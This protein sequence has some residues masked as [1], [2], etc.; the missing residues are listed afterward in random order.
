MHT[1]FAIPSDAVIGLCCVLLLNKCQNSVAL[2]GEQLWG[3]YSFSLDP[4]LNGDRSW[5][6]NWQKTDLSEDSAVGPEETKNRFL[7]LS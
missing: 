1:F 6:S 2:P 5:T 3:S 4:P 7:A